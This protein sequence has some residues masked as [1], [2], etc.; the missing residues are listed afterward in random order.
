V[1]AET[2]PGSEVK[3]HDSE[4]NIHVID[5]HPIAPLPRIP[6]CPPGNDVPWELMVR[7][8]VVLSVRIFGEGAGAWLFEEEVAR[9]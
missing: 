8:N 5:G 7:G 2:N 9:S 6:G 1:I 4:I 3:E